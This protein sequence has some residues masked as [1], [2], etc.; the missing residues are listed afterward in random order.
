MAPPAMMLQ[1][2][3][4]KLTGE[5]EWMV[6]SHNDDDD[7]DGHVTGNSHQLHSLSGEFLS[8]TDAPN[9]P[10]FFCFYNQSQLQNYEC[11]WICALAMAWART[12]CTP[13]SVGKCMPFDVEADPLGDLQLRVS[14]GSATASCCFIMSLNLGKFGNRGESVEIKYLAKVA[15]CPLRKLVTFLY[16]KLCLCKSLPRV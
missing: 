14:S 8:Y 9:W 2:V 6:I 15:L 10:D 1:Q 5:V 16:I 7:D 4:N 13:E 12:L 3:L 11:H